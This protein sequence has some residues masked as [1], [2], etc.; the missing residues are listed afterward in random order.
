MPVTPRIRPAVEADLDVAAEIEAAAD[1][2]LVERFAA[3]DWP[4]A[5]SAAERSALPGFV[6]VVESGDVPPAVIGFVHVLEIDGHAH[7]EQLSV[8]PQHGRRGHGRM[9]VTAA[10]A[11][12]LRRGHRS[13]TLRTYRDVPWNAP[14]YATCGFSETAPDSPFHH[15]LVETEARLGLERYGPRIQ[16]TAVL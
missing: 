4:E 14:F 13:M 5:A 15:Q 9:L 2:L 1:A 7:L 8:I 10:K 6:L 16:M 12:A 3:L 11:E